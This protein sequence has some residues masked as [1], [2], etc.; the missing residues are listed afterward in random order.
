M[1]SNES[2]L[3][4]L[5]TDLATGKIITDD[6]R[7]VLHREKVQ[8]VPDDWTIEPDLP[9]DDELELKRIRQK[10]WFKKMFIGSCVFA[11]ISLGIF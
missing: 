1:D 4:K 10:S 2:F 7:G 6:H 3:K 9:D 5:D 11:F 8:P